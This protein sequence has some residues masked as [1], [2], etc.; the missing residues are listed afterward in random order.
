IQVIPLHLHWGEET[1]L[2]GVDIQPEEF[3]ARLKQSSVNPTTSQPTPAAFKDIFEKLLKDDFEIINILISSKLSGT[4]DSAIQAKAFFPDAPIEIVDSQSTAMAM[5]FQVL[6][7]A[8]AAA[9]GANLAEC[10]SL[11][12]KAIN[13]TGV[14][15]A[16]DTLEFLHRGGRIGGGARFLGTALKMKPILE[17]KDGRVESVERVR[18]RRKSL[19][20]LVELVAE[21]VGTRSPVR[22]AALNAAAAED[23][24]WLME[25]TSQRLNPTEVVFSDVSPVIGTHTGPGTVAVAYMAGM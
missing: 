2:D 21:R 16:V 11:A 10:K 20:R 4:V 15:F 19:D 12:E 24:R 13:N 5:G 9:D 22:L 18:T 14:V 3:Y 17:I 23:A 8:Q 6:A 7:V 1:F 25:Q